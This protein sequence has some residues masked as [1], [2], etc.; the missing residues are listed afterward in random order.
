MKPLDQKDTLK[1]ERGSLL[2]QGL[3]ELESWLLSSNLSKAEK[4]AREIK[5][6]FKDYTSFR[7]EYLL[8]YFL[9]QAIWRDENLKDNPDFDRLN[10]AIGLYTRSI[11]SNE[12]DTDTRADACFQLGSAYITKR[13]ALARLGCSYDIIMRL[14]DCAIFYLGL[15]KKDKPSYASEVN[16]LVKKILRQREVLL[17]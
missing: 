2:N 4:K 16:P 17:N 6:E 1:E 9:A 12:R 10:E 5:E 8:D 11:L 14:G 13:G 3:N 7:E 15:A